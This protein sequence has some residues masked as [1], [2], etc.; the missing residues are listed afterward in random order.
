ML[1]EKAPRLRFL[2]LLA[3]LLVLPGCDRSAN[4]E[5]A[6]DEAPAAV[7]NHTPP[8]AVAKVPDACTFFSRA[9]LEEIIGWELREGEPEDVPVGSS[10]CDFE[11]P[12][13]MYVTRTFSDPALPQSVDFSSLMI[14]THPSNA[15]G[16][17][18]FRQ[19][20]GA[21]VEDVPGI[22][23]SAYFNGPDLL[24]VRVGDRGFSIRIYTNASTD[25]DWARIRDVMLTLAR[26]GES[27]L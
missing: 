9:E 18:E 15:A 23:D 10:S 27:R 25:A 4:N 20:L 12:P 5:A 3:G 24:Y 13:L 1:S 22:G 19:M 16:F 6:L 7:S 2:V 21:G 8:A 11:S 14:N 26:L 17:E